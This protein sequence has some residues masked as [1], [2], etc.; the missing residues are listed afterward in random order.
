MDE[1][2]Q[3]KNKKF[4]VT[5]TKAEHEDHNSYICTWSN[6]TYL[7]RTFV[8]GYEQALA[9]YKTLKR[10]GINMAKICFRDDEKKVIVFDHFPED[11]CLTQLSKGSL[12]DLYFEALFALYRF[13]RFS[14]VALDWEP[15]NFMLRGTQMFYLPTKW[16][17]LTEE[18][19]LEK[20]GIRTWFHGREGIDLLRR[21][22][23]DVSGLSLIQEN[24][25]NKSIVLTSVRFW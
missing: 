4:V 1:V 24:A 23:F 22:G 13:A 17:P 20:Q 14:K 21:K 5:A 2:I 11:D 10:A 15:Q 18:N 8:T 7:V 19:R 12:D 25:V 16:E 3:V 6:R 9:D